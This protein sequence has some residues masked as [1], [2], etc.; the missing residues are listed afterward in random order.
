MIL[1]EK[2][3]NKRNFETQ[4]NKK[5]LHVNFIHVQMYVPIPIIFK[6]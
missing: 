5:V 4:D 3:D 2:F 1:L 6:I